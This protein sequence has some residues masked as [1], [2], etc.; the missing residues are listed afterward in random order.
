MA[1][2]GESK[3]ESFEELSLGGVRADHATKPKF[4]CRLVAR[5][6]GDERAHEI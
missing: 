2:L 4:T 6:S 3:P 1:A 5:Q